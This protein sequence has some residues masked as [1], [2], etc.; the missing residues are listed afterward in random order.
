M[1]TK[2]LEGGWQRAEKP[3]AIK[4][5]LGSTPNV[6]LLTEKKCKY[7]L[8]LTDQLAF[9]T[10]LSQRGGSISIF[11]SPNAKKVKA[12]NE[13]ILWTTDRFEGALVHFFSVYIP[14]NNTEIAEIC[15]R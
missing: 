10:E 3:E 5:T 11:N 4:E 9:Q 6:L 8:E 15:L 1:N 7:K 13:N 2:V 14:Q 12:L